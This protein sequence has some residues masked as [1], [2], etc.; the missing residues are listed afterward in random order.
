MK[1][2]AYEIIRPC[3]RSTHYWVLSSFILHLTRWYL[4]EPKLS[5][6]KLHSARDTVAKSKNTLCEFEQG[7]NKVVSSCPKMA[8]I[9]GW[10]MS[11]CNWMW[12][13]RVTSTKAE[14][15]SVRGK[16]HTRR[17]WKSYFPPSLTIIVPTTIN[18]VLLRLAFKESGHV[19]SLSA[20]VQ[21]YP[22]G[23][24]CA[25]TEVKEWIRSV[26]VMKF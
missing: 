3:R 16:I 5:L 9:T 8:G 20:G 17:M 1:V 13:E 10:F 6:L 19:R 11:V 2:T 24:G 22:S 14:P 15:W 7:H 21:I 25:F 18:Y 26:W 23:G 4:N 12:K